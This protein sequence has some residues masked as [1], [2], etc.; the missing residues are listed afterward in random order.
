MKYIEYNPASAKNCIVRSFSLLTGE[1]CETIEEK[2]KNEAK[3]LG[4]KDYTDIEVFENYLENTMKF[5]KIPFDSDKTIKDLELPDGTYC[6]FCYDKKNFYHMIAVHNGLL[7]D[8][9]DA[10]LDLYPLAIYESKKLWINHLNSEIKSYR[11]NLSRI[12]G[13]DNF[14]TKYIIPANNEFNFPFILFVPDSLEDNSDLL[15]GI[16]TV[17]C[18]HET[19]DNAIDEIINFDRQKSQDTI[20][21]TNIRLAQEFNSAILVPIIPRT[22]G[23]DATYLGYELLDT[24]YDDENEFKDAKSAISKK[25][26]KFTRE[27]FKKFINLDNQVLKMIEYSRNFIQT[28][29]KKIVND[30]AILNGYSATSHFVNCFSAKHPTACLM[31]IGGGC[32]GRLIIPKDELNGEKLT[33]PVGVSNI[34]F[35][36]EEFAKIH[37]FYYVGSDDKS[38]GP[39]TPKFEVA[40]DFVDDNGVIHYKKDKFNNIVPALNSDGSIKYLLNSD[41]SFQV[42]YHDGYYS[43]EQINI[44]NRISQDSHELFDFVE[45][46][47]EDSGITCVFNRKYEGDHWSVI[48]N[49]ELINDIVAYYK[50]IKSNNLDRLK[51]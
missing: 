25:L 39:A 46:I 33:Y 23:L 18:S 16:Q 24:N 43:E 37:H 30:K 3:R 50:A 34:D 41:G 12:P 11:V 35:D 20:N 4:I 21:G 10:S 19:F 31:V 22:K 13:V 8:K 49:A 1:D 45:K 38:M 36:L 9:N 28:K 27:D 14:G 44:I 48:S 40:I 5:G 47:Y 17:D 2:L 6:I 29:E 26:T 15:V 42:L 32:G 7:F 51:K